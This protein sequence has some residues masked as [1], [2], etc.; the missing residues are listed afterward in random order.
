KE[1]QVPHPHVVSLQTRSANV[2]SAGQVE[3]K[4]LVVQALRMRPD[5]LVVGECRG[6]EI[7]DFLAA[8]NTGHQGAAGT[9]HANN[10]QSVPARLAALGALAGWSVQATALQ[11][12]SALDLVIHMNRGSHGQRGPVALGSLE[13]GSDGQ[14]QMRHLIDLEG[15]EPLAEYGRRFLADRF[16][17][18]LAR[19][20]A[21]A[22]GNESNKEH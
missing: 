6:S 16:G 19:T 14:M 13:T 12:S 9:M 3:L 10:P 15:A 5:R 22:L 2:E 20:V 21:T 4:D 17:Q 1:L 18:A 7:R 11:A 8:M